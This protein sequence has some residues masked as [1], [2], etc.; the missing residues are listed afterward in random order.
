MAQE[1]CTT[2]LTQLYLNSSAAAQ[3]GACGALL[4]L[5]EADA[6]RI[7]LQ[8]VYLAVARP[9]T[10]LERAVVQLCRS[11][12]AVALKVAWLL[13]ALHQDQPSNRHLALFREK[14]ECAAL[15][16][17]WPV[18]CWDLTRAIVNGAG[19]STSGAPATGGGG[20]SGHARLTPPAAAGAV[21]I[22]SGGAAAAAAARRGSVSPL[23][24]AAAGGDGLGSRRGSGGIGCFRASLEQARGSGPG[25][26]GGGVGRRRAA[27]DEE[28][29]DAPLAPL[30]PLEEFEARL[31]RLRRD[32]GEGEGVTALLRAARRAAEAARALDRFSEGAAAGGGGGSGGGGGGAAAG[33][34]REGGGGA[35]AAAAAAAGAPWLV[36]DEAE[37]TRLLSLSGLLSATPSTPAGRVRRDLFGASM[38]FAAAL[39]EA[40]RSLARFPQADRLPVLR[41]CLQRISAEVE[42]AAARGVPVLL[43]IGGGGPA[44]RVLRICADEAVIFN[45]AE[46]ARA[47]RT[48]PPANL[49]PPLAPPAPPRAAHLH[50]CRTGV[51]F[52]LTVE[53]LGED[54]A[55]DADALCSPTASCHHHHHHHH[56]HQSLHHHHSLHGHHSLHSLHQQQHTQQQPQQQPQQQ[57]E[58]SAREE[59]AQTPA[60]AAP[61]RGA[62]SPFPA[63]QPLKV[64]PP[65]ANG[66]AG[67]GLLSAA[68]RDARSGAAPSPPPP[69]L[70]PR[71]SDALLRSPPSALEV[72]MQEAAERL[73]GE[74]RLVRVRIRVL[75]DPA[76][77]AAAT[78]A[79]QALSASWHGDGG[80]AG[81][82]GVPLPVGGSS[83]W[84]GGGDGGA[85][86]AAAGNTGGPPDAA[87]GGGAA[88]S[89]LLQRLPFARKGSGGLLA[90]AA[91][92]AAPRLLELRLEV[93]A[94][95]GV[96][97]GVAPAARRRRR[98]PSF[99]AL[100]LMAGSVGGLAEIADVGPPLLAPAAGGGST[101]GSPRA[102]VAAA[103]PVAQQP[104]RGA[105]PSAAEDA[106]AARE[107]AMK[108]AAAAAAVYG[109]RWAQKARRL[110]RA[111]GARAA[112][113]GWAVRA[114]IVK[115]G[116]D[117]RQEA[118]ALQLIREFGAI[119]AEA[120]LPLWLRPF[121]AVVTSD[122]T[123]LIELIPDALSIHTIKARSGMSLSDYFLHRY[124]DDGSAPR[125][126][127]QR[128]FTESL[129]AYSLVKD[130]HNGNIM[131]DDAGRLIHIDFGFMLTNAPGRLPGGVGFEGSPMK[132]TREVLEVMGSDSNGAPSE[133]FDYFKVLCIQGF[134]AARKQRE[135]IITP[136]QVMSRSGFPCFQG[137]GDRAVRAL[138]GRFA[139][140]LSEGEVV[141]HVLGL[142]GDSLD[143]WSTRQYDAYQRVLNG[144]L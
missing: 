54:G 130:R 70:S 13:L 42:A 76:A 71:A 20:G 24:G 110:Q 15:D 81:G 58:P 21:D 53:V 45:S 35:A 5:P 115:S 27:W 52:L 126:A 59:P 101:G 72:A 3:E 93:P 1:E 142:I 116:D 138:S 34:R 2:I 79:Q 22:P 117:C 12:L 78:A 127:A 48:R 43:P 36:A 32:L 91:A 83:S 19:A 129:A 17:S 50:V 120:G 47:L 38:D 60:D 114:A 144:I 33:A 112:Q 69:L 102:A 64:A 98:M 66:S 136:V 141:P 40:S 97:L 67:A 7:L 134:L 25:P 4:Q 61:G 89:W 111:A 113:P 87:G 96:A 57:A 6:D 140:G 68:L 125:A 11:S 133:M 88:G 119:W 105:S 109:E 84:H 118:L 132:L 16:G 75:D 128:R 77:A 85:P 143:S 82:G 92:A 86:P 37:D 107:L 49:S 137:G 23:S 80:D 29:D 123:A 95:A 131:L 62:P 99:E 30:E 31:A 74:G 139:P 122:D 100:D 55:P 39:C 63:L 73:R 26:P 103:Q 104:A 108:Q 90:A 51:P 124:G 56:H 44:E 10:C 14:V 65:P 9:S 18:P 28:G 94:G 121:D 8:A 135:R 41:H 106:E 46:K